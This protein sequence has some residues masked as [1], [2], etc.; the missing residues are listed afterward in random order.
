M[1]VDTVASGGIDMR[2]PALGG[3]REHFVTQKKQIS[4]QN[5]CG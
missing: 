2:L 4:P 5:R 3:W 1:P